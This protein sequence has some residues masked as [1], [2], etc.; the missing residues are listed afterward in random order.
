MPQ[1]RISQESFGIT[2]EKYTVGMTAN[3]QART[4]DLEDRT[5]AFAW[6]VREFVKQVPRT[7]WNG[8][9]CGQLVRSSGSVGANYR[10][11][12]DS[13][14]K[15]DFLSR[16]KICRKEAKESRYWLDLLVCEKENLDHERIRLRQESL[17]LERIFGSIVRKLS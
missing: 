17:E 10:E 4:Y 6:S 8:D 9:D 3:L 5:L 7:Q 14:G 13:L 12:N 16:I 2:S 11:A 15:R 1:F